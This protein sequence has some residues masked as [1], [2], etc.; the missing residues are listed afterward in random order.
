[1]Q[2]VELDYK[3]VKI[4]VTGT[5]TDK[6]IETDLPMFE[7]DTVEYN[8]DDITKVAENWIDFSDLELEILNTLI[9]G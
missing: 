1:M 4:T 6:Q 7:I 2:I 9:Y 8:G 3:G 5:F